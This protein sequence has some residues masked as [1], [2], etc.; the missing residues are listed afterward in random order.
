MFSAP[1][2]LVFAWAAY[3][4]DNIYTN[5]LY[6][7]LSVISLMMGQKGLKHVRQCNCN[8]NVATLLLSVFCQTHICPV[9]GKYAEMKTMFATVY[10]QFSFS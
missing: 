2:C 6:I 3:P 10:H 9:H 1:I 7:L 5:V 8:G 4:N